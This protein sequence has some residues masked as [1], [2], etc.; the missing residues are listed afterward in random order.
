MVGLS[1]CTDFSEETSILAELSVLIVSEVPGQ[2]RTVAYSTVFALFRVKRMSCAVPAV[3]VVKAP[4]PI[5][6]GPSPYAVH[7]RVP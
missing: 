7:A 6:V 5:F 2:P 1:S 4:P 3:G